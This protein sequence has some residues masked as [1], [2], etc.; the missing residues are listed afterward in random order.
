MSGTN[1]VCVAYYK[2]GEHYECQVVCLAA[3]DSDDYQGAAKF[4]K[5]CQI[6]DAAFDLVC[7]EVD[8]F[9]NRWM[10]TNP[11]PWRKRVLDV[12]R[13]PS[14]LTETQITSEIQAE[15]SRIFDEHQQNAVDYKAAHDVWVELRHQT[16]LEHMKSIGLPTDN[17]DQYIEFRQ[18]SR[19]ERIYNTMLL[20]SRGTLLEKSK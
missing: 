8:V 2:I 3:F 9:Q 6:E 19:S 16:I 15:R 1:E 12:R 17:A 20:P 4:I 10:E 7:H 18:H 13:W 5:E 14:S 11:P